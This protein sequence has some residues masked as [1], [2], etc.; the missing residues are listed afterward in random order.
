M[1]TLYLRRVALLAAGLASALPA[2]SAHAQAASRF[3]ASMSG[4][5]PTL[6]DLNTNRLVISPSTLTVVNDTPLRA[7]TILVPQPNGFDLKVTL[8][9]DTNAPS[10]MGIISVPGLRLGPTVTYRDFREDAHQ[11]TVS[12]N[13][14][15]WGSMGWIYPKDIYSPVWVV[16]N[17]SYTIGVSLNYPVLQYKQQVQTQLVSAN[18]PELFGGKNWKV[19]FRLLG[20]L[21]AHESREYTVSVR[22]TDTPSDWIRTLV[23]Y[24]DYF[25]SLYGDV[26]YQ[27]DPR[28]VAGYSMAQPVTDTQNPYGFAT[29]TAS[30]PDLHGWSAVS[31]QLRNYRN[32]GYSRLMMWTPT[33]FYRVHTDMN[34]PFKFMTELNVPAPSRNSLDA[35]RSLA[36][37]E[38]HMG[39][40]WGN[41]QRVMPN[42]DTAESDVLNEN[43]PVLRARAFDELDMAVSLGATEIGL[44]FFAL[45]KPWDSYHWLKTMQQ[46]APGV[47]F[48]VEGLNADLFN[49]LTP[50]YTSAH[51]VSTPPML[52]DLLNPGHELWCGIMF[53]VLAERLGRPLTRLEKLA[54][55]DRVSRLGY[56]PVAFDA[57]VLDQPYIAQE[58]WL[59]SIPADVRGVVDEGGAPPAAPPNAITGGGSGG[60]GGGGGGGGAVSG[61]GGGGGGGYRGIGGGSA[62]GSSTSSAVQ[63]FRNSTGA[64][65]TYHGMTFTRRE[66]AEALKRFRN[67]TEPPIKTVDVPE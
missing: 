67:L 46:R 64:P 27:R 50:G 5:M 1:R 61:G 48:I 47:R 42:W 33:G 34:F 56:V 29:P 44:D 57:M 35:L 54:E 13:G 51:T 31:N 24:R 36:T 62:S 16:S 19:D 40:W 7:Q 41:S 15:Q 22:V 14:T 65:A 11:V 30:R 10:R 4:D 38:F 21:P 26:D 58:S 53:N 18:G 23:P 3:A 66:L 20:Q 59:T 45:M 49:N 63:T 8:F 37:P 60:G 12:H 28:P 43:D 25:R 32:M 52:A 55:I 2:A 6:R 9:N 39:Y 17:D